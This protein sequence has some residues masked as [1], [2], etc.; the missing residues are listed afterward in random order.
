MRPTA[1]CLGTPTGQYPK[2]VPYET[3]TVLG[4]TEVPPTATLVATNVDKYRYVILSS[5]PVTW[6]N[7]SSYGTSGTSYVSPQ[8]WTNG[9]SM[10]FT[11]ATPASGTQAWYVY[12]WSRYWGSC[13]AGG[14]FSVGGSTTNLSKSVQTTGWV[15]P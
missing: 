10:S 4:W 5:A 2:A 13:T 11:V 8:A 1:T 9:A 3:N 7:S 12:E 14:G 15:G 6:C